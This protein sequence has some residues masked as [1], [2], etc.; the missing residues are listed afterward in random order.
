MSWFGLA[1]LSGLTDLE[2]IEFGTV[3]HSLIQAFICRWHPETNTFHFPWGGMTITLHDVAII[4]GLQIDGVAPRTPMTDAQRRSFLTTRLGIS[5]AD[6]SSRGARFRQEKLEEMMKAM[7][8]NGD[9]YAQSVATGYL[10]I[11]LGAIF[12]N[13]KSTTHIP[14]WAVDLVYNHAMTGQYSWGVAMLALLYRALGIASREGVG[15]MSGCAALV[16]VFL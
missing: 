11:V 15:T 14:L 6:M 5:T 1:R 12:I 16:Q 10:L 3:D 8:P 2:D 4:L 9:A 13:D 7:I